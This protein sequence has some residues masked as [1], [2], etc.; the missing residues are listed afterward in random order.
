M[1]HRQRKRSFSSELAYLLGLITLAFGTALME[2]ADFGVSM[3]V[4]PAYVLYRAIS[5]Q[6]SFFT[7]G[8]AEYV[9]QAV[10]LLAMFA[11]LRRMQLS[12]LFS[13]V[14][15]VIYGLLLDGAMLALRPIPFDL[16][17][18]RLVGYGLGMLLCSLGV[19]LVFHTYIA[20]EVY[21][22]FVKKL[23]K[24]YAV[25]IHRFKTGYDCISC[26]VGLVLSFCCFG[27]G[28]FVGIRL[29]TIVCALV[30]GALIGL[31]SRLL[32]DRFTFIDKLPL[33]GFFESELKTT[34]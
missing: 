19:S 21:E 8:M 23:S 15:A 24:K 14:T 18:I 4:A 3:V 31:F 27:F 30:N 22:L 25:P 6:L 5:P 17:A 7:F 16:L 33:R 2:K 34:P 12:D 11:L 28:Q 20:P 10:L 13:F 29:G 1:L 9:L 32:E 26:V